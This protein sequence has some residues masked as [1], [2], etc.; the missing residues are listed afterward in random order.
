MKIAFLA[1]SFLQ[2]KSTGI[3]GAQVQMYNLALAFQNAGLEVHYITLSNAYTRKDEIINGINIH[4]IPNKNVLFS[5]IENIKI[6]NQILDK[7]Q[8]EA[9]YQRGRSPLTYIAATW[10]KK[11]QKKFIWG[12]NGEDSCEFWKRIKHLN[13]SQKPLWRKLLLS[14]DMI[15]QDL[16]IH[17]GIFEA[18]QVVNQTEHQK[19]ELSQ[20]FEKKGI[21]LPS[22]FLPPATKTLKKEKIVLWLANLNPNK[23]PEIFLKFVE[24]N[25]D[26]SWKF[27]L[28]GGS[29][30]KNYLQNI[31]TKAAKNKNLKVLG[32]IPFEETH[33]YYAQASLFVNTSLKEADGLPNAFIQSWQN[34]TPVL[35]L[36]HD[37][38]DWIKTHNLGYC[39]HGNE[40][41]FLRHGRNLL[42]NYEQIEAIRENCYQF[43]LKTFAASETIDNYLKLFK[44]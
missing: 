15:I 40:E 17:K 16:L 5:W 22:Y 41:E 26:L 8:P 39:A 9:L 4:W 32:V 38:N 18:N 43:A 42:D 35:S 10:S 27:I 36:N 14:P 11:H 28:G 6:F 34:S 13:K 44:S 31:L 12:S 20:N 2:D 30:N 23:Q 37:P 25:K 19:N 21:I 7:I 1:E 24:Q 29:K 3:N 33:K